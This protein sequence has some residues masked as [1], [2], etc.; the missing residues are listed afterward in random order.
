MK[1]ASCSVA[2]ALAFMLNACGTSDSSTAA[3][4]ATWSNSAMQAIV[5]SKCATSGCH[6][7]TQAPNFAAISEA[8]MK[9]NTTARNRMITTKDMPPAGSTGLTAAEIAT[10]TAFYQ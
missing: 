8:D 7:G 10:V 1:L 5:T 4:S 3:A 6:N 9:A 2:F